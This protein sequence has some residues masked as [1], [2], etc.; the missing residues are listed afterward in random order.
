MQ[1][2][3]KVFSIAR[4]GAQARSRG[5]SPQGALALAETSG[6]SVQK[7]AGS[8]RG[9]D[10]SLAGA[11]AKSDDDRWGS[12]WNASYKM[13]DELASPQKTRCK[14]CSALAASGLPTPWDSTEEGNAFSRDPDIC[15]ACLAHDFS[16]MARGDSLKRHFAVTFGLLLAV[17][18]SYGVTLWRHGAIL[19]HFGW[20]AS[21]WSALIFLALAMIVLAVPCML[22]MSFIAVML[23]SGERSNSGQ[24]ENRSAEAERFYWLAVWASLSGREQ[25]K[26]EMLERAKSL[27]FQRDLESR[28][29]KK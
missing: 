14:L 28:A 9:Y 2:L 26:T 8:R 13:A 16:A 11:F 15:D 18:T 19:K 1:D 10:C 21:F 12:D 4:S 6:R 7:P 3:W 25:F 27:G 29:I 22:F 5:A 17:I 23:F 20:P 24:Q